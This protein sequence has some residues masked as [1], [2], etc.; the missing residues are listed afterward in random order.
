MDFTEREVSLLK[1]LLARVGAHSQD[2]ARLFY[3]NL[4]RIRPE[5]RD[6][7][8]A[9]IDRQ[10]DK[11]FATLNAVI[12]QIDTWSAI[13]HQVEQLGLRHVAYGVLTEHYVPTGQALSEMFAETLG[14][15]F[16]EES[17]AAWNKAYDAL[18]H[19]MITALDRRKTVT[20]HI[21]LED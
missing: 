1:Q 16:D 8:V 20:Q 4:F 9:D 6:L 10:G 15:D 12:L 13:E 17:E 21:Q 18:S 11:L 2:A 5:T 7:F 3:D 14:D 19:A